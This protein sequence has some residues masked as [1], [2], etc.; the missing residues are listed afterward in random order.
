MNKTYLN[1]FH[2]A[3]NGN[4]V[5]FSGWEMPINYGSQI[6]EHNEVRANVGVFDVSHMAVFDFL[7][8]NQV[9]FLRKLLPN[10]VNKILNAKRALYSP[11][12]N[13][14]G[15]ILD[16]LIVYHT[17]NNNFR[18]ISNCATRQQ[19][20]LWF[21]EN[22]KQFGVEVNF[23]ENASIIAIQGPNSAKIL[24][25]LYSIDL[26]NFHIYQDDEVM[27]AR[28][29]YT[30]EIGFEII[31]N[32]EKGLELW[33]HFISK[34]VRPI[35]LAARDTL[36]LEAGLNLYGSDMSIDNHPYESNLGWTIDNTDTN[37]AYIGKESI[38]NEANTKK[39]VGFYTE[40][41]GVLRAGSKVYFPGGEGVVTSGTWSPTFKKNIGF[42]RV[43][44]NYP[45]QGNALL[46]DK[47]INLHFC[48]TN[49]L[50]HLK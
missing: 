21:N 24:S 1:E 4:L 7:G 27:I 11:L 37:R 49:F 5:D 17:G 13:E 43:D 26:K 46:R 31:S 35:G 16:D 34:D 44:A 22:A 18:I 42:C 48:E 9:E 29:G 33:N 10:D 39:L 30:G 41:R 45:A 25:S 36:R 19:N 12:L 2:S 38:A 47:E 3:H 8:G 6:N 15:R 40:E 32:Q 14:N 23:Q 28:T 50:K 20:K